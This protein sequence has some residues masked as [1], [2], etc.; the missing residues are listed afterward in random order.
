MWKNRKIIRENRL[1]AIK[2]WHERKRLFHEKLRE[3]YNQTGA[4]KDIHQYQTWAKEDEKSDKK[5][6][7][8][9]NHEFKTEV[10][11]LYWHQEDIPSPYQCDDCGSTTVCAC[12]YK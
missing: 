10:E 11:N 6:V 1:A 12:K 8:E 9:K 7:K 3:P 4:M 5:Q 2:N